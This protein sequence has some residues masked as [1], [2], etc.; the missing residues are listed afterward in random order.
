MSVSSIF[1]APINNP[2]IQGLRFACEEHIRGTYQ[3]WEKRICEPIIWHN[4]DCQSSWERLNEASHSKDD[5]I[6]R[7][8]SLQA[9]DLFWKLFEETKQSTSL[10]CKEDFYFFSSFFSQIANHYVT[11]AG[12]SLVQRLIGQKSL[13]Y[14]AILTL[15]LSFEKNQLRLEV[16]DNGTGIAHSVE[17]QLFHQS[18]TTKSSQDVGKESEIPHYGGVGCALLNV[19][20]YK[21]NLDGQAGFVNKGLNQGALFWFEAR[22]ENC[23]RE[24]NNPAYQKQQM[25]RQYQEDCIIS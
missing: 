13:N 19:N 25:R 3:E 12:D 23:R 15:R 17:S 5:K 14:E 1:V 18:V 9:L 4:G 20:K 10:P 2:P 11:N 21:A 16:E 8:I 24:Y 22:L 7:L 6:L